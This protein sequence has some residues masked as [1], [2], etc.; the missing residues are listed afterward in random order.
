VL[1]CLDWL[2]QCYHFESWICWRLFRLNPIG[3]HWS[4]HNV[5]ISTWNLN[6]YD[7]HGTNPRNPYVDDMVSMLLKT[8]RGS[9][10]VS[11]WVSVLVGSYSLCEVSKSQKMPIQ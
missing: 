1:H 11:L 6:Y 10:D 9:P 7:F 5:E 4:I 8:E 3:S 2:Y